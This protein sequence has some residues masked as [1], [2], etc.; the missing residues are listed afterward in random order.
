MSSYH[1]SFTYNKNSSKNFQCAILHFDADSGESDSGLSQ[2]QVYTESYNGT[3]RILYGTRYNSVPTFKI[4]LIK[5]DFTEFSLEECRNIYKWLTGNNQADWLELYVMDE[6]K[7][8][9]L[10]TIQDVKPYKLDA[11]TVGLIVYCESIS[12]WAYSQT[13]IIEEQI[14]G[15]IS[16]LINNESDDRHTFIYPKIIYKNVSGSSLEI[17]NNDTGEK[18]SISD[19][20]IN[21]I[22]T[23]DNNMFIVSD[24]PKKIFGDSFIYTW[25]RIKP[26]INNLTVIGNGQIVFEYCY[27][28]KVGDCAIDIDDVYCSTDSNSG[29]AML[30]NTL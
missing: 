24:N 11:R 17:I 6:M 20:S 22:V 28:I 4:A 9:F 21:E 15:Q 16:I 5:Q 29:F 7:Y 18:T 13:Q 10:C 19:L 26:G 8:R 2:E 1:S 25:P 3:K 12:P 23:L 30:T 14:D 27:P